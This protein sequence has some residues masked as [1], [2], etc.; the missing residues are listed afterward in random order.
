[1]KTRLGGTLNKAFSRDLSVGLRAGLH[2]LET[3][4][5]PLRGLSEAVEGWLSPQDGTGLLNTCDKR[6]TGNPGFR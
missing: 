4:L 5:R 2:E 3:V 6:L 1:M